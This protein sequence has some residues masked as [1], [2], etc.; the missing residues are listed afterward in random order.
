MCSASL[1]RT[2]VL[3]RLLQCCVTL[4]A[5]SHSMGEHLQG[6][7]LAFLLPRL[8]DGCLVMLALFYDDHDNEQVIC[9]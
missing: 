9:L 5:F 8:H 4:S 1:I 7:M 2:V 6:C 3:G